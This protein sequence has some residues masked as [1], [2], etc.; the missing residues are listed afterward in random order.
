[1]FV[2]YARSAFVLSVFSGIVEQLN[3]L[4]V[5]FSLSYQDEILVLVL[6]VTL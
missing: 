4:F 2:C 5:L 3:A 1:M 6:I